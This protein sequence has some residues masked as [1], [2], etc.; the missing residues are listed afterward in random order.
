VAV[1]GVKVAAAWVEAR[2]VGFGGEGGEFAALIPLS[3]TLQFGTNTYVV[4]KGEKARV[5]ARVRRPV[6]LKTRS[7]TGQSLRFRKAQETRAS[8]P[9]GHGTGGLGAG[10]AGGV[11]VVVAKD[12]TKAMTVCGTWAVTAE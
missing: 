8:F 3:E 5:A 6:A 10:T 4:A 1:R 11:L 12:G 9:L 7:G 2:R